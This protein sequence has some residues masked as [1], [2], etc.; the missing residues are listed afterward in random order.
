[1]V[2]VMKKIYVCSKKPS[3]NILNTALKERNTSM[4]K[5]FWQALNEL[6]QDG[7]L[8]LF[9]TFNNYKNAIKLVT[10]GC[11]Y[12]PVLDC[13]VWA[14]GTKIQYEYSIV[15]ILLNQDKNLLLPHIKFRF[16]DEEATKHLL[17]NHTVSYVSVLLCQYGSIWDLPWSTSV[18]TRLR[19]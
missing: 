3:C 6:M 19:S 11:K 2:G 9:F 14:S 17:P 1:M 18:G 16:W 12:Y 7:F 8:E 15:H 4:T 13:L 10:I 5:M